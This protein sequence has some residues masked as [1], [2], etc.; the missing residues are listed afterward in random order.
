MASAQLTGVLDH[1]R[2]LREAHEFA[3]AP[4]AQLLEGFTARREEAAFTALVRRHGPM[5]LNVARRVLP[6]TQDAEDVFQ[7]T[8]LLLARKAAAIRKQESVGSWLYGVTYRLAVREKARHARQQ[9][10]EK[11]AATVRDKGRDLD[12]AWQELRAALNA[13]LADLPEKYRAALVLCYLEGKAHAEAALI[14]D[15]PLATLRTRVARGRKLLH[16]RLTAKGLTLSTAGL[17]AL[18]LASAAP[19]VAPP[20]LVKAT[21]R[22]ALPFAAGQVAA[23]LASARVA[24]LVEGGL[25]A[26]NLTKAK[27]A[28]AILL[29]V[30]AFAGAAAWMAQTAIARPVEEQAAAAQ[31][32]AKPQAAD[33]KEEAKPQ[34]ATTKEA[35]DGALTYSG[36]VVDP[37]GKPVVGAKLYLTK[38]WYYSNRPAASPLYATTDEE[39]RFTFTVPKA[40]FAKEHVALVA[41]AGGFGASWVEVDPGNQ[42]EN[43][44]F[45]VSK[46]DVPVTGQIVDLQ[47]KPVTGA[48][49]RV[50]EIHAAPQD[51]LGPWLEAV[52]GSKGNSIHLQHQHLTRRLVS[53]EVPALARNVKTDADG[54]FRISGI[55]RDRVVI[56]RVDAPAIASQ[57]LH[58]LTRA[59]KAIEAPEAIANPEYGLE[60]LTITYYPAAFKH[61]AGPTKPVVGVVRDKDTRKPLAGV[62]VK[63][64]KLANNPVHGLDFLETKTD[65]Q[66]RYRL[67]GMPKGKGN[68]VLFVPR[69]D[70]PYLLVHAEVPDTDGFDPVTVD[71]ELKRGVWIEG[72][73]T[74]KV[75]G[76]RVSCNVQY[77]SLFGNPNVSDHPGYP[78]T[79]VNKPNWKED[80]TFRVVGLPGPGVLAVWA[81]ERYLPAMERDD[82]DGTKTFAL[83]TDPVH[84]SASSNNALARLDPPKDAETFN[85]DVI[86]DPGATFTG[87]LVGPDGKPIEGALSYGLTSQAGWE[88]PGLKTAE[89]TV[90]AFNP[91]RPRPVL[92]RHVEKGLVG[93]FQP[94]KDASKPVTV[95]L[96]P[97]ATVTGRLIDVF[98]RP[99]ANVE[100]NVTMHAN[101]NSIGYSLP[102]K[103]KTD[104]AGRF[105][106]ETLLPGYEFE[107]YDHQ[108]SLRFG[109]GLRSGA[110]K[111]LGDVEIKRGGE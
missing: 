58:V 93:V 67:T 62:T 44:T 95:R 66:G 88:R 22:A 40:P 64:Y 11:G 90:S 8:F 63:S 34:A 50:Q 82:A 15:C 76:K 70:Q 55:G 5:V 69:E 78:G 36:R 14:L 1:L 107:L 111:N 110:T 75:T 91:R 51:N 68:K 46:D 53:M 100:M 28:T 7:A 61:V 56:L 87:T 19:A 103:V 12:G 26:M 104:G 89:F 65:A 35:V 39:G 73:V 4:D 86:L 81:S 9:A 96:Q 79:F 52:K 102:N 84:V 23:D 99:R 54:K 57:E 97:G 18:F 29:A 59:G 71:F 30:G 47:G 32:K 31:E 60:G 108:G 72:K 20:A 80:G 101:G 24:G 37:D 33:A 6:G 41:T 106:I 109:D 2:S 77:F 10:R 27:I 38:A 48:L 13:A 21:V 43:V 49:V 17:T 92:F 85:R 3:E 16:D 83:G 94:P 74:D 42:K 25:R 98:G 45:R 105:R